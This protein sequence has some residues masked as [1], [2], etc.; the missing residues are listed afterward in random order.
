MCHITSGFDFS[1]LQLSDGWMFCNVITSIN[2]EKVQGWDSSGSYV[3][4]LISAQPFSPVPERGIR[5]ME[6]FPR[7][8]LLS[9]APEASGFQN[10]CRD[11]PEQNQ[12]CFSALR[13]PSFVSTEG[14]RLS[15]R[16][17]RLSGRDVLMCGDQNHRQEG[18]SKDGTSMAPTPNLQA[19][20]CTHTLTVTHS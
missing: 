8:E 18:R 19:A 20:V 14:R 3:S 2:E 16:M 6:N 10:G 17:K 1:L 5:C 12:N 4:N 11:G 15:Q 9:A 7:N 13:R